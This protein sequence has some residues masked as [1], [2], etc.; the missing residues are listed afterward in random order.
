MVHSES[1]NDRDK[2]SG[3]FHFAQGLLASRGKVLLRMQDTGLGCFLEAELADLPG[4]ALGPDPDNWLVLQRLRETQ[5][6]S[7]DGLLVEWV[8]GRFDDP[9]RPPRVKPVR[10]L[11]VAIEDA[12]APCELDLVDTDDYHPLAEEGAAA[13]RVKVGLR[14]DRLSEVGS[15]L[16]RWKDGP[17]EAWAQAERPIRR[18]IKLYNSL[19]K[20]HN[21]MHGG[22]AATPPELVWGIGLA[23]WAQGGAQ[24]DMPLIEQLVDLEVL[25]GGAL[26]VKP[27]EVRPSLSLKPF[28]EADVEG[29]SEAQRYL[30]EQFGR[31]AESDDFEITPFDPTAWEPLLDAA[32]TRLSS[33]ATHVSR[34][35]LREG[36]AIGGPEADLRVYSA[37]A[38]YGRPRSEDLREQD[39]ERLRNQVERTETDDHLPGSLRGFVAPKPEAPIDAGDDWGLTRTT[40]GGDPGW[41]GGTSAPLGGGAAPGETL[42]GNAPPPTASK[43]YFF[44]LAY[45]EE[46]AQIIDR[47]EREDVVTVTGPPGTGK[48]HSIANIISHYMATGQRVLVTARTPEAI[49][50][51][52]DKLPRDLANLVIASVASDREGVKQLEAAIQRLSD[53]VVT[54]DVARTRGEIQRLE[55]EV[56]GIDE[57]TRACDRTLAEI[58]TRNLEP[59]RWDGV[60]RTAMETAEVIASLAERHDWMTDRPDREPPTTLDATIDRLRVALPRLAEDVVYLDAGLPDLSELPTTAELLDAHRQEVAH[61]NRPQEDFS[62]VPPMARDT[63]DAE[64]WAATVHTAL[65]TFRTSLD[66]AAAW[67]R[68]A[69]AAHLQA[70][71]LGADAP[72]LL[73][74]VQTAAG[75]VRDYDPGLVEYRVEDGLRDRLVDA[76][77][78]ACEGKRPLSAVSAV[79]NRGLAEAV[80]SVRLDGGVPG[81]P[82]EW[83]RVRDA[84]KVE[85]LRGEL[86]NA[87]APHV[88]RGHLPPLPDTAAGLVALVRE[89]EARLGPLMNAVECVLA[90][91]EALKALFPYGLAIDDCLMGLDLAPLLRALRANLTDDYQPPAALGRLD[92]IAARGGQ[93]LYAQIGELRRAI[94]TE[95][96]DDA[97]IVQA[98]T[99]VTQEIRR[100]MGLQGELAALGR[101]LA[102][103]REAGAPA[104]A[105]AC[106]A[107][108]TAVERTLPEDWR[109]SWAWA[110]MRGRLDRIIALGNGDALRAR[111]MELRKRRERVFEQL[112]RER[113][114]LGLKRRLTGPVQTALSTFTTAVRRLGKG[115]GMSAARWRKA[116]R[117]AALEAAPAA[118][119]WVMPEYKVAEQLPAELADF[120][121]VILDEASQSDITA[122]GA[123]ARGRKH[124]IVGDEQ[125]VSPSAVGIPQ[126][127]ID[128]L[129]AEHLRFLPNRDVIDENTS[130]FDI[131]LQMYPHTHLMLR[132]HFRCVEPIIQFSTRFYSGRLIPI[133]VPKALERFDPPVV[134][135]FVKD[136]ERDGKTNPAEARF[137][138]DEIAAIARDPQHGHRDIAVISLIGGEQADLIER[139]LIE[140]PR[141]GT[142]VMERLRIVCG[143]SRTLQGQER[144]V[145]FL[146]MVATRETARVQNSQAFAQRFNV[147]LS[148]ARDRLYLV[149]SVSTHDLRPGDL[150]LAVLEHFQNPMPEGRALVGK[151]VLE[152]C[153]SGFEREVCQMLLDA[154][155]RVRSQVKAGP[156]SIDLVVEGADDR[157]LAIEL[158]GDAWHGP[159]KWHDDMA[160]Q[161]ALERAG[162]TF[163][164]VFGSQWL[165]DRDHW[166]QNL[167]DTMAH[168]GI[169]PIGAEAS[170]DIFT[171]R[172]VVGPGGAVD[173]TDA[174]R[175]QSQA[176][177]QAL[178]TTETTAGAGATVAARAHTRGFHDAKYR[179]YLG[180]HDDLQR[181]RGPMAAW[182]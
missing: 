39:L 178:S 77:A 112:I 17:W 30:Q 114:L 125:Q 113:T 102:H 63:A 164:R 135:V 145:V 71:L 103:L 139:M 31:I 74:S 26:A 105:A 141:V 59:L 97:Q 28:L 152:R 130:I 120:D 34:E 156:F 158:D 10:V 143:D 57:A 40:L 175:V 157:R 137:I 41:P 83:Q 107:A 43:V 15:A 96:I 100:L 82:A 159:D 89:A 166:W 98:R 115:T 73:A 19:F 116:I 172:R 81:E 119:V 72:R 94:G 48:T 6:P 70:R 24:I 37:W 20:L 51:V 5:P 150:K 38:I 134:D 174:E 155:Y 8:D 46:Q 13:E 165:T 177:D 64:A 148:R 53:D 44:P 33:R 118:P 99:A 173:R 168:M 49:A 86:G 75:L 69:I 12:S 84:L 58:A 22:S 179:T 2:L 142:E 78:R 50:A 95:E 136:G 60:E 90:H 133:R 68:S 29:A 123:L 92:A 140:D 18:S 7:P 110:V 154:N 76:V 129:R 127:K 61:R 162:W 14:L 104:W 25:P 52:R 54:L 109:T 66:G 91:A 161:A 21:M 124:L 11:D 163:W 131:A 132:E 87:W 36:A 56:V 23:R 144:S 122:I 27:R 147:A 171:E 47:L 3:L 181:A 126:H 32:A 170:E 80:A 88:S 128:V 146:S 1:V 101:D 176:A 79:F 65:A 108:P 4:V 169:A 42:P 62:G 85:D 9:A 180:L 138:V 106:V 160:R 182:L 149:R 16:A 121:L 35:A 153:E 111:K 55:A 151:G 167:L 93:P 67:E 45:N 117:K